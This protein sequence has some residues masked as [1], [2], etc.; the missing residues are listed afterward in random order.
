MLN[1]PKKHT[2]LCIFYKTSWF[3]LTGLLSSIEAQY[4]QW[5]QT[6]PALFRAG[7]QWLN[8]LQQSHRLY[9]MHHVQFVKYFVFSYYHLIIYFVYPCV[10]C[11]LLILL[12]SSAT[13]FWLNW[14]VCCPILSC[15]Y[16][17]QQIWNKFLL[18]EMHSVFILSTG[19][20]GLLRSMF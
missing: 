1:V 10:F 12:Y 17:N 6:I 14:L 16:L 13:V 2:W 7:P 9:R 20:R 3:L 19:L 4:H 15:T 8:V 18:S 5:H 11:E